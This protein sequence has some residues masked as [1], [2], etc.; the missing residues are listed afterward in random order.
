MNFEKNHYPR[1]KGRG[2]FYLLVLA[3][4]AMSAL[5]G[6]CPGGGGDT[7]TLELSYTAITGTVDTAITAA[8]PTWS[9]TPEGDVAYAID[10]AL[11]AGL[12]LASDTGIIS[13]TPT[14]AAAAKEYTI[15]AT[16][17]D[18]TVK[19]ATISI[20]IEE[21]AEL[22]DAEKVAADKADLDITTAAGGDLEAVNLDFTLPTTGGKGT[23]ISWEVTSGTAIALSGTSGETAAV[24]RP[25]ISGTDDTV[26]LRA[27][28]TL[29]TESDT[30][31]FTL[32]V[33][34]LENQIDIASLDP[35]DFSLTVDNTNTTALTGGTHSVTVG[36]SLSLAAG[37]DYGLSIT[38]PGV[39]S[40]AVSIADDGTITMTSAI[41]L[42]DTGDYT[43]T[44]TGTGN[45]T[46]TV[47]D[48]FTLTVTKKS[49]TAAG[50]A[51]TIGATSVTAGTGSSHQV[52]IS[53]GFTAGDDYI[54]EITP[55]AGAAAN[56]LSIT[57]TGDITIAAAIAQGDGGTYTVTATGQ[58]N[59]SGTV[60]ATF[61]LTVTD[62]PTLGSITYDN[63]DFTLG[64][65]IANQSPIGT[66]SGEA[67]YAMKTGENL[68][69]GLNLAADGTISGTP[70]AGSPQT[71]YTIVATGKTGTVYDGDTT[72]IIIL[73]SVASLPGAPTI[74]SVAP[75]D[76]KLT[77]S[78]DA[79]ADKGYS[80]GSE[81]VIS[82]YTVYWGTSTGVT[83]G[84]T[85]KATV[86][87]PA[88]SYEIPS[89]TNGDTYYVIVT[90]TTGAGEGPASTES[91]AAPIADSLPEAPANINIT[92]GDAKLTVSWDALANTGIYNGI[93]G[94]ISGYTV[95]WDTSSGVSK[96]SANSHTTGAGATSYEITGL[97]NNQEVYV[98]VTATTGAGEGP[99][100]TAVSATPVP[101]DA[102]PGK[103]T[104][105]SI[106]QGDGKLVVRWSAP[107]DKGFFNGIEGV[108]SE[109]TVYW[110]VAPGVTTGST[111][112]ATV[113]APA[114][115]YEKSGLT[116]G[117]NYYFIVTATT[118]MGEG[119]A[120]DEVSAAP[121]AGNTPP[122][123][124][125]NVS[126][127][128]GSTQVEVSWTAPG[129]TGIVGGQAGV[130]SYRVYY[131]TTQGF[132]IGQADGSKEA[133][134]SATS[135]MVDGLTDLTT[136][137]F[138][139]VAFTAAGE[140]PPSGEVS[141]MPMSVVFDVN[142]GTGDAA[143]M[144]LGGLSGTI[145]DS[146]YGTLTKDGFAFAGWNTAADGSGTTYRS[147]E[148]YNFQGLTTL[149][150][151]WL[152]AT[153]ELKYVLINN[154]AEYTVFYDKDGLTQG[155]VDLV[156][157]VTIPAYWQEKPVTEIGKSVSLPADE[158]AFFQYSQATG[159]SL[160][161]S[162]LA[163]VTMPEG[164][165][166][167]H[168]GAFT[169][170][171]LSN[172]TS[173]PDSVT[174]IHGYAFQLSSVALSSFPPNLEHIGLSGFQGVTTLT[175]T[176][177]PAGVTIRDYPF[178]NAKVTFNNI[179]DVTLSGG[180]HFWEATFTDP[181]VTLTT[182]STT[183]RETFRGSNVTSVD[184]T[185][186]NETNRTLLERTF[187]DC[188]SLT[189]VTVRYGSSVAADNRKVPQYTD[190]F[191]GASSLTAIYV[192]ADLVDDFKNATGIA[193]GWSTHKDII[194]AIP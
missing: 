88:T 26:V 160:V 194:H 84:S 93:A 54:L 115:S 24:T 174:H 144:M 19:T 148:A 167:I 63:G 156:T 18:N 65:Q 5:L 30:K 10:P 149:Y 126:A 184:L 37:T 178:R 39:T 1:A 49:L 130:P 177:F 189:T 142:G 2:K 112:K 21:A 124:P 56:H 82:E 136:Y 166:T 165:K 44:A 23:A 48:D 58:N 50:L 38:G 173:L 52:A 105:T 168:E 11:P 164:L 157:S 89:L 161:F 155:A 91:S 169:Q 114:T 20:T 146:S 53:Q 66:N 70:T 97:T 72:E 81:G 12:E 188:S 172:V 25:G 141:A 101:D 140:S 170:A 180:Q 75:G 99:A 116:N 71:S 8:N 139:V 77:V 15:T 137:Y 120:S 22:S 62:Q 163:S 45:Y 118:G 87:A 64:D 7:P 193:A 185:L 107:A 106:D 80:G 14:A 98:I 92:P 85:D 125:T 150:A 143:E 162:N 79:P 111:D 159:G 186:L 16:L 122:G 86:Q 61:T 42:S 31:D 29:G 176:A 9:S 134:N 59:Y 4:I 131:S 175:P 51:L 41:V 46:G 69:A 187:Q 3:V 190:A 40:G 129:N 95:Y 35:S 96:S 74:T 73:I 108:I 132:D 13:G 121:V 113:Q 135:L 43:V 182:S 145:P 76:T 90:A 67:T 158:R 68:P 94:V 60:S 33:K 36:G 78:W 191:S 128:A 57:N 102:L 28:I 127:T 110:K 47:S 179:A 153:A 154:D 117:Q 83:T 138:K 6:A 109:Y 183:L 147:G 123:A 152:T 181:A 119:P 34:K 32:T 104:I 151:E 171:S 103:P 27:T 55:P 17:A 100:P 192:P 133:G